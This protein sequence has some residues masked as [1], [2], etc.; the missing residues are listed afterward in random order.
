MKVGFALDK[1]PIPKVM[2]WGM[3]DSKFARPVH[4]LVMMHGRRTIRGRVMDIESSNRTLGHRVLA[5]GPIR[6][7]HADDYE[8]VLRKQ[9]KVLADFAERRAAIA[10]PAREARRRRRSSWRGKPCSTRSRRSSKHR[11]C[12]PG[13][14]IRRF[15]KCRRNA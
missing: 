4:G 1:L 12:T 2:R 6:L 5:R 9:G 8:A 13:S 11:P 7:A 15:S 3:G 14:S 10:G